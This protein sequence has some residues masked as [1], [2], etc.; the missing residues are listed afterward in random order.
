MST[1]AIPI[2]PLPAQSPEST[3]ASSRYTDAY[4]EARAVVWIGQIIKTI[5]WILGTIVGSAAVAAY[6][7]QPELRRIAPATEAVPLALAICA[8]IAVL[9]FWVWGVLV[10]SKGNHLKAS[11]DC[12]VNSSPF[13]SN[14]QRAKVMSLN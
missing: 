1:A 9:V 13:L 14:E 10:C 4:R 5:G 3:K 6:V 12:A 7:E 2:S 8:I 11:L